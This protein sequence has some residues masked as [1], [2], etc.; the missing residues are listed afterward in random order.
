MI[1]EFVRKHIGRIIEYKSY[2]I[3]PRKM[4]F[5]FGSPGHTNMGDQAQ[6]YCIQTWLKHNYPNYG[7]RIYTLGM[8]NE[9]LYYLLRKFIRKQDL[10]ICHSGYHI[11]DL[12]NERIPYMELAKRFKDHRI[13]IFPQTIFYYDEK[14]LRET[15][16]IFNSHGNVLLMCR[17]FVS[18]ETA[19]KYFTSCRLMLMPDIVTSLIGTR[20][21]EC[22]RDGVLFCMRNDKEAFYSKSDIENLQ[23]RISNVNVEMADTTL[24]LYTQ[25]VIENREKLLFEI[26]EKYAQYRVIITDRYHGT[27]FS[28]ISGTPVVVVGSTDHKL[29]SGVQWF[30]ADFSDY[31]YFANNLDEAY[32]MVMSILNQQVVASTLPPY[33]KENYYDNLKSQIENL[34]A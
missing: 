13:I 34:F 17:D 14:K 4:I 22:E 5:L 32:D 8:S 10:L 11:T 15:A 2:I 23:K 12:Y 3:R 25:Y 21:Y 6:T 9:R 31:V 1:L 24:E 18:F 20:N 19:Q 16:D 28:L 33:F 29:S 26:F 7:Q 30:P 27:I